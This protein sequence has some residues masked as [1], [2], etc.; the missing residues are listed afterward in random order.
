[1]G[2][3]TIQ[4]SKAS[5]AA[6]TRTRLI[7]LRRFFGP[8]HRGEGSVSGAAGVWVVSGTVCVVSMA[9]TPLC[10][11]LKRFSRPLQ[12]RTAV[13]DRRPDP[14]GLLSHLTARPLAFPKEKLKNSLNFPAP[15]Y[16][17]P[18]TREKVKGIPANGPAVFH[19]KQAA[20]R[21]KRFLILWAACP[22]SGAWADAPRSVSRGRR[23][24]AVAG[25]PIFPLE[26]QI[27]QVQ[28]RGAGLL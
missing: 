20:H 2:R 8:V 11:E 22:M 16:L 26:N 27:V 3:T 23:T 12:V 25:K 18:S 17:T 14:P 9:L 5:T 28:G 19:K 21:I 4:N 24:S 13:W 10:T 15:V 7:H 6:I 1:M